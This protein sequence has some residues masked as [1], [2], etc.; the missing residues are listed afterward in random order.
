M[1]TS[2]TEDGKDRIPA[3]HIV[4]SDIPD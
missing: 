4:I 2:K 3:T 1:A